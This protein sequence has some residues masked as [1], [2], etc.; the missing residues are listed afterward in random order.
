MSAGDPRLEE[1]RE[2]LLETIQAIESRRHEWVEYARVLAAGLVGQWQRQVRTTAAELS[3]QSQKIHRLVSSA[4]PVAV[5]GWDAAIWK[6]DLPIPEVLAD[7]RIGRLTDPEAESLSPAAS[8]D[9]PFLVPLVGAAGPIVIQCDAASAPAARAALCSLVLRAAVGIPDLRFTLLAP[10][11]GGAGLPIGRH[12]AAARP[13]SVRPTGA[14]PG[15]DLAAVVAEIARLHREVLFDVPRMEALAPARRPEGAFELVV[16]ADYP[17][18]YAGDPAALEALASIARSG[19]SAGRYLIVEHRTDQPEPAGLRL[20][21]ID[22]A[23]VVAAS[24]PSAWGMRLTLDTPPAD[25]RVRA[26]LAR[27]GGR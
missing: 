26:L 25:D 17:D 16:A 15:A 7:V 6:G 1:M 11:T 8:L 23:T 22:H 24:E 27:Q 13:A 10:V 5:A 14:S 18:G 21:T 12:L 9:A 20:R 2:E 3:Q 4:P 19:T